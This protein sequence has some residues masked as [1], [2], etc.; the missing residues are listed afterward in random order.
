MGAEWA[1]MGQWIF[2]NILIL[3]NIQIV[4]VDVRAQ[5]PENGGSGL[6]PVCVSHTTDTDFRCCPFPQLKLGCMA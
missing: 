1:L 6:E 4:S 3:M 2:C 5:A